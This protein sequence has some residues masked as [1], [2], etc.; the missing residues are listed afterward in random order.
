MVS[1]SM[2]TNGACLSIL[3]TFLKRNKELA[4]YY[5]CMHTYIHRLGE[6]YT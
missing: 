5:A 4:Y 3:L 1:S 6:G 2:Y